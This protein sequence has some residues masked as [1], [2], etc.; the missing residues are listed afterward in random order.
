[1]RIP[2]HSLLV[3]IPP[4]MNLSLILC[5]EQQASQPFAMRWQP[6][7]TF[8]P[9]DALAARQAYTMQQ[10]R[11]EAD[12]FRKGYD[13]QLQQVVRLLQQPAPPGG[14]PNDPLLVPP[15]NDEGASGRQPQE[16]GAEPEDTASLSLP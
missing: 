2:W 7:D 9:E 12:G 10:G 14:G 6:T 13:R 8:R 5:Q 11:A 1:M 3:F 15:P 4:L 16:G